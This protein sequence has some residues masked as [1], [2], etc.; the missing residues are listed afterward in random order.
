VSEDSSS[1]SE[2][3]SNVGKLLND[4]LSTVK[5]YLNNRRLRKEKGKEKERFPKIVSR[6]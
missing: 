6:L 3:P 1:S 5:A 4:M 2:S